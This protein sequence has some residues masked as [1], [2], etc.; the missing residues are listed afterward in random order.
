[1]DDADIAA[2]GSGQYEDIGKKVL[3]VSEE[4]IIAF[5]ENLRTV[6]GQA[7]L[8]RLEKWDSRN[9]SLG[10]Y[11]Q[12]RQ[13]LYSIDDEKTWSKFR[14][15][16]A[17]V[18]ITGKLPNTAAYKLLLTERDW[19]SLGGV[20][21]GT[22]V[23][24]A[25]DVFAE[26]SRSLAL[27]DMKLALLESV[28]ALEMALDEFSRR[29]RLAGRDPLKAIPQ[30]ANATLPVRVGC[31]AAVRGGIDPK[32]VISALDAISLRNKVVHDGERPSEND[33]RLAARDVL[34]LAARFCD[35]EPRIVSPLAPC[36]IPED[37]W[38]EV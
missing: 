29:M 25:L 4:P 35:P 34:Q 28:T 20:H 33:A 3:R 13:A 36:V 17:L 7:W 31:L 14:P 18:H 11:W 2:L 27:A 24:I 10:A 22:R 37:K 5:V 21:A 15:G 8:P 38:N 32:H 19:Q 26:A 30:L 12:H 16:N 23:P 9:E 6:F 1:V